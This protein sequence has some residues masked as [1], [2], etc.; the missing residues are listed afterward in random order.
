MNNIDTAIVTL[1]IS[2][3]PK[4]S[5]IKNY[6]FKNKHY[7]DWIGY[8]KFSLEKLNTDPRLSKEEQQIVKEQKKLINR[9]RK[10]K[11]PGPYLKKR[12]DHFTPLVELIL[13]YEQ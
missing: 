5:T 3:N 1:V 11:R 4:L 13:K 12:L 9:F 7:T 10:S 6:L 2:K 8:L